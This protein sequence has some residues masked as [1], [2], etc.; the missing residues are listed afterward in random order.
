MAVLAV[1]LQQLFCQNVL[2][3]KSTLSRDGEVDKLGPGWRF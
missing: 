1:W 3:Y 2:E